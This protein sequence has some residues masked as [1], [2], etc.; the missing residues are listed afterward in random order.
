M[1]DNKLETE[2]SKI[3]ET[4]RDFLSSEQD[5]PLGVD[6]AVALRGPELGQVGQLVV[7]GDLPHVGRGGDAVRDQGPRGNGPT[8]PGV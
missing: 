4:H 6:D 7:P 5:L 8:V 3:Y 2:H 1:R